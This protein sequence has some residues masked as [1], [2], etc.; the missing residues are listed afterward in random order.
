MAKQVPI[1]TANKCANVVIGGA[2]MAYEMIAAESKISVDMIKQEVILLGDITLD[3]RLI[4]SVSMANQPAHD[5]QII[6]IPAHPRIK[7]RTI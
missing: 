6:D 2:M 3:S 5:A 1:P 4:I 7:H